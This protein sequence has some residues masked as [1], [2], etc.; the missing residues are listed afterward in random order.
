MHYEVSSIE[1]PESMIEVNRD[2]PSISAIFSNQQQCIAR[3]AQAAQQHRRDGDQ[4]A[5][6][7]AHGNRNANCVI[8]ERKNQILIDF[9]IYL[10]SQL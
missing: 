2:Q 10:R 3:H 8:E 4:G 7:A 6:Q 9:F 1:H 5:E